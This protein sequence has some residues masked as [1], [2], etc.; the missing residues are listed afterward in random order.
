VS[1][2]PGHCNAVGPVVDTC[3]EACETC[4]VVAVNPLVLGCSTAC[5]CL[6]VLLPPRQTV[7]I[8]WF[9]RLACLQVSVLHCR[10]SV[11]P[12]GTLVGILVFLPVCLSWVQLLSTPFVAV[13]IG[14]LGR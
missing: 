14:I 7:L 12:A 3:K 8:N 10:R 13:A 6:S 2:N 5:V 9:T 4:F 11:S 1:F